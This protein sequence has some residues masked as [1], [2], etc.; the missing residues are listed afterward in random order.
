MSDVLN[1]TRKKPGTGPELGWNSPLLCQC[2][3][4][5]AAF[6]QFWYMYCISVQFWRY[7]GFVLVKELVRF[8]SD[9]PKWSSYSYNT[10]V[11][12]GHLDTAHALN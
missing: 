8:R 5:K 7:T 9:V 1:R 4:S 3:P 2:Y 11:S 10:Y 6:V 12:M